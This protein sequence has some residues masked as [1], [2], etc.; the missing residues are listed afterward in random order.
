MFVMP[1]IGDRSKINVTSHGLHCTPLSGPWQVVSVPLNST[2]SPEKIVFADALTVPECTHLQLALYPEQ[3]YWGSHL[4]QINEQAWVYRQLFH[5]P[6]T[7]NMSYRRA[8]LRFEGVDYFA[9]VW[10]NGQFIGQ[11]EGHFA[12][13]TFDVTDVLSPD[14]ENVLVVR[15]SAPWDR[16]N[17]RGNYPIDHVIRGLVKG[18]YEHGDGVIPPDVNPIGIWRPVSLLLDNGLSL[19]HARIRTQTDGTVDARL[20]ITNATAQAWRGVL[21]LDIVA[22]NHDGPGCAGSIPVELSPGTHQIDQT[23][24]VPEPCLWWPWDQGDPNLYRLHAALCNA[25]GSEVSTLTRTFGLRTVRL[26]RAPDRFTYYVNDRPVYVRGA[27]YMPDLYLSRCTADTLNR[28]ITLARQANLN[29]LRLHI[30][31]SPP[32]LYDLCDRAGMLVW[33]DFEL[34]WTHDYS[35]AFEARAL[36]LQRDMIVLLGNHP[37]I[38][39][40]ACH[41]EPTMVFTRRQNLEQRPDP[42]LYKDAIQLDPTRPVFLCSGQMESDWQRAGDIHSYYGAIWSAN[43]TEVYHHRSRLTTEFGCDA[44][45]ALDTLRTYREVWERLD[46]LDGHIDALWAYQAALIQFQIEHF[47][48]LRS[49]CS[50]GFIYFWL[51][52]LI[53]QIGCGVLDACRQSKAGYEALR[54]A[55]QPLHVALEHDGR[56]P[57]ALWIFNDIPQNY[58][59][60]TMCW[61]VRDQ[62]DKVILEGQTQVDV[63]PNTSQ[64]VMTI[65][66]PVSPAACARVDLALH[67]SDGTILSRNTYQAPFQ[68]LRRPRGYPWKYDPVLGT[69][70]FDQPGAASLADQNMHPALKIIPLAV[71]EACAEW[72]LRQ[73]LPTWFVSGIARLAAP[74]AE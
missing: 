73:R 63:A 25:D 3:P 29:L 26:D 33:Q 47:R 21:S 71:R 55:C 70:V 66:W 68:P 41:N 36:A 32:E 6:S 40:W 60:V 31:V 69:K 19:D 16:P 56:R 46:H 51:V 64:R 14:A 22:E 57:R 35:P 20:T 45:A 48:R 23:L 59:R 42:A 52:D 18:Q 43:Y 2:D 44:P 1:M 10:L 11:H 30:H 39:T 17:P 74:F 12:P 24:H 28:D 72:V 13:F 7:P 4:R 62:Q 58:S 61:N 53:P 8:R 34:N 67:D 9:S 38:M 15:V 54:Q 27:S 65:P 37:S 5:T 49:E 50:G